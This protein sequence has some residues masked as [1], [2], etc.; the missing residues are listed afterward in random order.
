MT[1]PPP[2]A[3][4]A[5]RPIGPA[6][7][8]CSPVRNV[9]R[10]GAAGGIRSFDFGNGPDATPCRWVQRTVPSVSPRGPYRWREAELP[11]HVD[12]LKTAA[13]T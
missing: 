11:V 13:Q 5:G 7:R 10:I 12:T 6:V 8:R 4:D 3:G 9:C 1:E 2:G